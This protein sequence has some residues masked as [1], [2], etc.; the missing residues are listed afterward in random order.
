MIDTTVNLI[1]VYQTADQMRRISE[2]YYSDLGAWLK[3]PLLQFYGFVCLLPYKADPIGIETVSRPRYTLDP[4]YAPRDCDDKSVLIASWCQGNG[5][6][7][8]FVS[9][10]TRP[11]KRL[12]HVFVQLDNGLFIDAT[13]PKFKNYLGNYP[14]FPRVTHIEGLTPFF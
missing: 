7:K 6:K 11:D 4:N 2:K 10:S 9:T 8:R 13:Y 1:D 12:C 3:V 5:R 14:Y